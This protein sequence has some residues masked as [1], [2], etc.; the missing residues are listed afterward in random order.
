M[1]TNSGPCQGQAPADLAHQTDPL[2]RYKRILLPIGQPSEATYR[3]TRR[4]SLPSIPVVV[5][6]QNRAKAVVADAR[7]YSPFRVLRGDRSL[8]LE[9]RERVATDY[10]REAWVGEGRTQALVSMLVPNSPV[11]I[12]VSEGVATPAGCQIR[13]AQQ[14]SGAQI[15]AGQEIIVNPQLRDQFGNASS[16]A[17]GAVT[18][19]L[20][21]PDGASVAVSVRKQPALGGYE[22]RCEPHEQGSYS[23][24]V[25]LHGT[26][27]SDSPVAFHITPGPPNGGKSRL[28]PPLEPTQ[29][30]GE[31]PCEIVL[32]CLDKFG[33]LIHTGGATVAARA[34][35]PGTSAA[36]V[37]DLQNGRYAIR[38]TQAAAG[39]CKVM[40]RLDNQDVPPMVL[41]FKVDASFKKMDEASA[42][43]AAA[44]AA[45]APAR[46]EAA[47]APVE[48]EPAAAP[49]PTRT[50]TGRE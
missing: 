5:E 10:W 47:P 19:T 24:N 29:K 34:L 48:R 2:I 41:Q 46:A 13:G 23:L 18:A 12:R 37:D 22:I 17:D 32:E 49:A 16:A 39:E 45:A 25:R 21:G 28:L 15:P 40:V 1:H 26:P 38:F 27:I 33:N 44:P 7:V 30:I 43:S 42:P 8:T 36:T 3:K 11:S 50:V 14:V 4:A 35:G 9:L 31:P 20:D 6:V